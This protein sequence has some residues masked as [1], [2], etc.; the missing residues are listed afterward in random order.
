MTRIERIEAELEKMRRYTR[1]A[2]QRNDLVWLMRNKKKTEELERELQ[3]AR[4]YAP[5]RLSDILSDKGEEVKNR[6]YKSLLKISLA[7][8]FVNDCA[9]E[10]KEVM[11]SLGL[12]DFTLR[13][14]VDELCKLS[15]KI[16][17]FVIIPNQNV[18][19]DM[20]CDNSA[21]IDTAHEAADKHLNDKLGL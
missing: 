6:V 13:S 4:A 19:T 14:E 3:K 1:E 9:E 18:L 16:A 8:D 5:T 21:F 7:A 12:N 11:R 15:Q 2:T 20:I 17:S 10:T